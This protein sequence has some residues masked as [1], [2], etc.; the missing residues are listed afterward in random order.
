MSVVGEEAL[1]FWKDLRKSGFLRV[2][3]GGESKGDCMQGRAC[4][5]AKKGSIPGVVRERKWL[6]ESEAETY[7]ETWKKMRTCYEICPAAYCPISCPNSGNLFDNQLD[8]WLQLDV[9]N[10]SN[11]ALN[12]Y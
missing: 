8:F 9:I 3:L 6:S 1:C 2:G 5:K 12:N 11:N 7:G 4:T 10:N